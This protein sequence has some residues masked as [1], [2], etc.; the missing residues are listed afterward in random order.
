MKT[1]FKILIVLVAIILAALV[2]I[3]IVYKAEITELAKKEI[4]KQINAKVEF[5][6]MD[7]GLIKSFPNFNLEISDF[8]IVG[9]DEFEKDTLCNIK[10]INI[11]IDLF[12]VLKGNAYKI[13]SISLNKP[14]INIKILENAQANYNITLPDTLETQIN[15]SSEE[16]N[17]KLAIDRFSISDGIINYV[18]E[19]MQM[20]IHLKGINHKLSGE[21]SADRAII[22]SSTRAEEFILDYD[23]VRYFNNVAAVYNSRIDADL[24]NG[25]YTLGRNELI[26]NKFPISFDGSVSFVG[27][28][29]INLVLSF[30]TA[31]NNFK[32]FLSLI[33]AIYKTDFEGIKTQG[34]F[35]LNGNVKG[36]YNDKTLPSFNVNLVFRMQAFNIL[37]Y[38]LPLKILMPNVKYQIKVAMPIIPSST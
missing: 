4:N 29:D 17:I 26:L 12:S 28:D 16:E 25:I 23:G 34:K 8:S 33:P 20:E 35:S 38:R 3:P 37:I 6:D 32:N 27:Q 9:M 2:I 5:A 19:D 1:L 21:L 10:A 30:S 11:K 14:V 36:I 22:T 31:D 18:D 24:K 13:K 15:S 7:L